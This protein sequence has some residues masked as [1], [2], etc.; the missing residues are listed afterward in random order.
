[1]VEN[2]WKRL[3]TL[4]KGGNGLKHFK[5][6]DNNLKVVENG[7]KTFKNGDKRLKKDDNA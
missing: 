5:M 3:K 6:A 7:L 4:L 2:G 1:M